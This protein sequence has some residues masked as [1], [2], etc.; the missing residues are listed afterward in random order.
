MNL[1]S[2]FGRGT[3][4]EYFEEYRLKEKAE[5]QESDEPSDESDEV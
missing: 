1:E 4:D 3:I 5:L 2:E